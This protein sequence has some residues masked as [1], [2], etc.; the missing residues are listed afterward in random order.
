MFGRKWSRRAIVG[1][2][3]AVLVL[4]AA[5]GL[6]RSRT[7]AQIAQVPFSDLLRHLDRGALA[8]VVIN[9]DTLDFKLT[10]GETFRTTA[11][12]NYVTSN[13]TFVPEL[14]RRNVRFDAPAPNPE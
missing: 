9:G 2:A 3:I 10:S 7:G 8:E 11:P 6:L 5:L 1:S 14:A 13:G 4:I 12:A